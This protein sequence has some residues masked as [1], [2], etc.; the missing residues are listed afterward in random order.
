MTAPDQAGRVRRLHLDVAAYLQDSDYAGAHD[1][2]R[3]LAEATNSTPVSLQWSSTSDIF[4]E[5]S[6]ISWAVPGLQMAPGRPMMIAGFGGSMKTLAAQQMALAM[7]TGRTVWEQF[8][9]P[10]QL[11]VRHVDM[12]QGLRSTRRRYQRLAIGHG[13]DWEEIGGRLELA[14]F[15]DLYLTS[16]SAESA[17]RRAAEGVDVVICDSLRALCP[18]VAENDSEIRTYIDML[19]RLSDEL[20]VVFVILHHSGKPSEDRADNRT[21]PRGSSAIF[22]A[23][24]CAFLI[25]GSG[26]DPRKVQQIK[27][28]ADA[29]GGEVEPF[30]LV[31]EDAGIGTNPRA[32][33]RVVYRT[34]EQVVPPKKFGS[35]YDELK[36]LLLRAVEEVGSM[37]SRNQIIVRVPGN[38]AAKLEAINELLEEGRL[39]EVAGSIRPG[40]AS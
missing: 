16:K 10:A 14:S 4:A 7:T 35:E 30:Y 36:E 5:L 24:G 37:K 19:T 22:D 33:V 9:V 27:C 40:S 31:V 25:S 11:R 2:I 32:G 29:E 34:T 1:A 21:K 3:R 12:E 6:P 8:H 15:P 38:R 23:V 20:D 26:Q 39:S 17:W 18:G 28:P 13:I